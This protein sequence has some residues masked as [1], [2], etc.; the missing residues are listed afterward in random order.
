M[1]ALKLSLGADDESVIFYCP[2]CKTAHRI[3]VGSGKW[4]YNDDSEQPTIHPSIDA[5][6]MVDRK[7]VRCHSF[8]VNG[9]IRFCKDS[10]HTMAGQRIMLPHIPQ[11]I[12]DFWN[13]CVKD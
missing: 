5:R 6:L 7:Q 10:S 9:Q 1:K 12:A 11:D 3:T 2:A 13:G 4:I 8:V